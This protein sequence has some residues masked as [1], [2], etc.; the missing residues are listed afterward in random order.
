MAVGVESLQEAAQ[1]LGEDIEKH[2]RAGLE[3]LG[4]GPPREQSDA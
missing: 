4:E 1:E 2:D 3:A